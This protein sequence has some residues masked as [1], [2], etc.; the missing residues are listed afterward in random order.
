M[1]S[2]AHDSFPWGHTLTILSS[3]QST[4]IDDPPHSAQR[5]VQACFV[6]TDG[7]TDRP[8]V[9]G[10]SRAQQVGGTWMRLPR[11]TAYYGHDGWAAA[12]RT[13]GLRECLEESEPLCFVKCTTDT[14]GAAVYY[15]QHNPGIP[16]PFSHSHTTLLLRYDIIVNV[17]NNYSGP[18]HVSIFSSSRDARFEIKVVVVSSPNIS[19]SRDKKRRDSGTPHA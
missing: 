13:A 4:S 17:R 16:G 14:R 9:G 15:A 1:P 11:L 12:G 6:Q 3:T 18:D 2:N 7:Q 19:P 10:T 5:S 8:S